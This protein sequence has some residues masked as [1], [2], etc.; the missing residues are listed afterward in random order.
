MAKMP[1]WSCEEIGFLRA[2]WPWLPVSEIQKTIPRSRQA[3]VLMANT[4]LRLKTDREAAWADNWRFILDN[5]YE[6]LAVPERAYLAGIIDGEGTIDKQSGRGFWRVSVGNTN[7]DLIDW[8]HGIVPYSKV[9]KNKLRFHWKQ[10]WRWALLSNIKVFRLLQV[11]S[12]FLIVKRLKAMEA[13]NDLFP[14]WER[15]HKLTQAGDVR[16]GV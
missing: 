10:S 9:T 13:L 15:M 14:K 7:K 8:L 6:S 1:P 5:P 2:S 12:E 16:A 11:V 3:I 4:R